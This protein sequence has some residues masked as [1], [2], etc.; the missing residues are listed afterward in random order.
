MPEKAKFVD[1]QYQVHGPCLKK[2]GFFI[3][4]L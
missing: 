4:G 1:Y 2:Q 3:Y